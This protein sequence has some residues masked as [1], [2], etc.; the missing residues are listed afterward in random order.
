MILIER[1]SDDDS[2][3]DLA[4]TRTLNDTPFDTEPQSDIGVFVGVQGDV[5]VDFE[6]GFGAE[7]MFPGSTISDI[8]LMVDIDGISELERLSVS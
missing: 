5:F 3:D 8:S 2:V 4:A 6:E 1:P 7:R